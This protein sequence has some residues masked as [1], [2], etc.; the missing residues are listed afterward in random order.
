MANYY[1]VA[2][3]VIPLLVLALVVD[4]RLRTN[5]SQP[6]MQTAFVVLAMFLAAIGEGAALKVLLRGSDGTGIEAGIVAVSLAA[7]ALCIALV[8]TGSI[9]QT[10][11]KERVV[12]MC[13]SKAGR[14]LV[15]VSLTFIVIGALVGIFFLAH[16][17]SPS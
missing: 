3:Q 16:N 14:R 17:A 6:G 13:Q 9:S 5:S 8:V 1:A 12:Q 11:C 10:G 2:A 15:D 4:L 7:L